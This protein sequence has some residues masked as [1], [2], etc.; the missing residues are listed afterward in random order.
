MESEIGKVNTLK[1]I[2]RMGYGRAEFPLL[3][4]PV[5]HTLELL[6]KGSSRM[7]NTWTSGKQRASPKVNQIANVSNCPECWALVSTFSGKT[8]LHL[9]S[10]TDIL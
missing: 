1:L 6:S 5:L 8:A 3:R 7:R 9:A 10:F 4:K 2:K